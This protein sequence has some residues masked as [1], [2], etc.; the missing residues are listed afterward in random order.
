MAK[1]NSI[2]QTAELSKY[3]EQIDS[4]TLDLERAYI[5]EQIPY[6]TATKMSV[7]AGI[8]ALAAGVKCSEKKTLLKAGQFNTLTAAVEKALENE[9]SSSTNNSSVLF[10][11]QNNGYK[12]SFR[13]VQSSQSEDSEDEAT[14]SHEQTVHSADS[15]D[16]DLVKFT[17]MPVNVFSIKIVLK[18]G[19][20]AQ[21]NYEQIFPRVY[22]RTITR[23]VFGMPII[24]KMFKDY[25]DPKRTNCIF[26]PESLW[27][28]I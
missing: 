7:M 11:K 14:S 12:N 15:D 24:F 1:L 8:K 19:P 6:E 3:T 4:L 23:R 16:S 27:N 22:R 21:D 20:D 10:Y 5:G 17:E 28:L 26:C 2:K 13:G 25:M 9:P 18:I